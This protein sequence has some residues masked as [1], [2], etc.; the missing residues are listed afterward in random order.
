MARPADN[1]YLALVLVDQVLCNGKPESGAALAPGHH[2]IEQGV[3]DI[4]GDPGAIVDNVDLARR[5]SACHELT[6]GGQYG[7]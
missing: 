5:G 1:F 2:G 3:L 6:P 7:S 4:T